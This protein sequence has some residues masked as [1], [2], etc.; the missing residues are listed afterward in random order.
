MRSRPLLIAGRVALWAAVILVFGRGLVSLVSEPAARDASPKTATVVAAGEG[1]PT[2]AA[3]AFA[4]RFTADYLTYD[5]TNPADWQH[6]IGGYGTDTLVGGWDGKG[7]QTVSTVI[8]G[9]AE[10]TNATFGVMTV[11]AQTTTGW[12]ALGVPVA[13]TPTGLAVAARPAFVAV[14][15]PGKNSDLQAV[16]GDP[17]GADELR[18]TVEAFL[19]AYAAGQTAVVHALT[20]DGAHIPELEGSRF[21]LAG[22]DAITV[23]TTTPADETARTALV[24]VRWSD[25]RSGAALAQTYRI[26]LARAGERWLVTSLG[27]VRP[28][29]TPNPQKEK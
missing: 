10:V 20:A 15:P 13:A 29:P 9:P 26:G 3:E 5:E 16:A 21:T 22:I 12:L 8:P 1:Y 28:E 4:A 14:P 2:A 17:R 24:T 11:A 23:P 7:H 27:P 19:A 18:P 25:S 6:R